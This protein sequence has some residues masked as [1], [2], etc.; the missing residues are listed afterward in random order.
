MTDSAPLV[1]TRV[2]PR[3]GATLATALASS[4][5]GSVPNTLRSSS[6]LTLRWTATVVTANSPPQ[7]LHV[8]PTLS[9]LNA[10]HRLSRLRDMATARVLAKPFASFHTVPTA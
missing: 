9:S 7:S 3:F 6:Q 10:V 5:P 1:I 4:A 8:R 2:A